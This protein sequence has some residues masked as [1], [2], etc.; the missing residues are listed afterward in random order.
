MAGESTFYLQ[1]SGTSRVRKPRDNFDSVKWQRQR[2]VT[3]LTA[4][5][6]L[7]YEQINPEKTFYSPRSVNEFRPGMLSLWP[8]WEYS[9]L[10]RPVKNSHVSVKS[11]TALN[12]WLTNRPFAGSG[13]LVRNKLCWDANSAVG[14]NPA[15]A[16]KK[17]THRFADKGRL[18]W[19]QATQAHNTRSYIV[20]FFTFM[21]TFS[22]TWLSPRSIWRCCV[23]TVGRFEFLKVCMGK[24]RFC[25]LS[26]FC[27]YFVNKIYL[28]C[29]CVVF[30]LFA[31]SSGRSN[32]ISASYRL[33]G[34]H[35]Y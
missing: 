2:Q 23:T 16:S 33:V 24:Q 19:S 15:L 10:S 14:L 3:P 35:C 28:P 13:H 17:V 26:Q 8:L 1:L 20:L 9:K 29:C 25:Q 4:I 18:D 7:P 32:V 30:L 5:I 34:F 6:F 27:L 22:E 31:S 12:S 21:R 11:L